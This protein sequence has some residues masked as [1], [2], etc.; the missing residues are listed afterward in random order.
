MLLQINAFIFKIHS[1]IS[2]QA[3][4]RYQRKFMYEWKMSPILMLC[5]ICHALLG[6]AG[7]ENAGGYHHN[8][9]LQWDWAV[10]SLA[11]YPWRGDERV[12]DIGCGDGKIT[13]LLAKNLPD[14]FVVGLDISP[15]MIEYASTIFNTS[16]NHNLLFLKG[17][18]LTIP[19]HA[20]FDVAVSFLCLHWVLDQEAAL[21]KIHQSLVPG[22]KILL[23]LPAKSPSNLAPVCEALV[24]T[25]KWEP[26]FPS[27]KT[28][29]VYFSPE[30]YQTLL[31]DA[32]FES[33]ETTLTT[34]EDHYP[35]K[36]AFLEWLDPLITFIS[37]LPQTLQRDFLEETA[38]LMLAP[39]P[40]QQDDLVLQSDKLEVI[41]QKK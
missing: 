25:E 31:Q 16:D 37:H 26:Y 32:G 9:S 10:E 22:G 24:K 17:E 6:A 40:Q 2:V 38:E 14:G 15:Q 18:A 33:I 29:R 12:L 41:A 34:H 1:V 30:E 20:Q 19:F 27:F 35:N 23:V 3:Q 21:K 7:I 8:S 36:A 13:A 28:Q 39:Y 4:R 5:L 11:S